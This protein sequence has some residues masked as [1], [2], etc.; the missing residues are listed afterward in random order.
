MYPVFKPTENYRD[1]S[2]SKEMRRRILI[3]NSLIRTTNIN[4]KRKKVLNKSIPNSGKLPKLVLPNIISIGTKLKLLNRLYKPNKK[5]EK[6]LLNTSLT[7]PSKLTRKSF[8]SNLPILEDNEREH[9]VLPLNLV[10][11]TY[12]SLE[13]KQTS[14]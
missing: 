4:Y 2:L 14:S 3:R 11:L 8:V 1:I 5:N 6:L 13:F 12:I 7:Q 10:L 9:I